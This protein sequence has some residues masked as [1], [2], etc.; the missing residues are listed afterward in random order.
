[1]MDPETQR[2]I[3]ALR[4]QVAELQAWRRERD[5]TDDRR[6]DALDQHVKGIVGGAQRVVETGARAAMASVTDKLE[7]LDQIWALTREQ[8]AMLE[9]ARTER[10]RRA[11]KDDASAE[12][13]RRTDIDKQAREARRKHL[14][15]V[16][17][18][19]VPIVAALAG[20]I[21]AALGSHK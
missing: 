10:L 4:K 1:M 3:D 6:T 21:G 7:R 15:A 19:L 17:A 9:D 20:L 18:I 8:T 13:E 5:A 2:A 11:A 12:L 16:A 14:L